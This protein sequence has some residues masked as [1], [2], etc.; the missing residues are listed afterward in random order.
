[1]DDL[2]VVG[3]SMTPFGPHPDDTLD[4]MVGAVLDVALTNLYYEGDSALVARSK[5]GT[6]SQ[7]INGDPK[8]PAFNMAT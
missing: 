8:I 1:M 3:V 7:Q 5:F 4:T 2:Y 6:D